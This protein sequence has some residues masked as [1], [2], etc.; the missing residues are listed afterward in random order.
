MLFSFCFCVLKPTNRCFRFV[1]VYLLYP[2][3]KQSLFLLCFCIPTKQ[4][5]VF[6]LFLNKFYNKVQ[7]RDREIEKLKKWKTCS[8]NWKIE[9]SWIIE[10]IITVLNDWQIERSHSSSVWIEKLK[11]WFSEGEG[12]LFINRNMILSIFITWIDRLYYRLINTR[13]DFF[14]FINL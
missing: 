7:V 8:N 4:I 6:V 10:R 9:N 14:N 13:A 11:D 5:V 12:K 1:F 3:I 2:E